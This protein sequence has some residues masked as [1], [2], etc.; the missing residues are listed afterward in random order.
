MWTVPL[1]RLTLDAAPQVKSRGALCIRPEPCGGFAVIRPADHAATSAFCGHARAKDHGKGEIMRGTSTKKLETILVVD[2]D[3]QVLKVVVEILKLAKFQVLSAGNGVRAMDTWLYTVQINPSG[4]VAIVKSGY[5]SWTIF[6]GN[7]FF[8]NVRKS[9]R[10][11]RISTKGRRVQ[12]C[13]SVAR[14]PFNAH[15]RHCLAASWSNC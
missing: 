6:R 14:Y 13:R 8:G 2:D 5:N 10:R 15:F 3:E 9:R 1:C 4:T 7:D 12:R 11:L